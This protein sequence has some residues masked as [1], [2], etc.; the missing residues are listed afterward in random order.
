MF[1]SSMGKEWQI[2]SGGLPVISSL[3]N[4]GVR[5]ELDMVEEKNLG[6]LLMEYLEDI[7]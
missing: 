6:V 3:G 1:G 4:V 2:V 7:I 5:G